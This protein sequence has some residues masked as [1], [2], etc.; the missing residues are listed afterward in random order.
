M[1]AEISYERTVTPHGRG[2]SVPNDQAPRLYDF[3]EQSMMAAV[4][5]FNALEMF[6]NQ[7][8]ADK[9]PDTYTRTTKRRQEEFTAEKLQRQLST[10]EKLATVLPEILEIDPPKGTP[11]WS[12]FGKLKRARDST[13]H[14]KT[15]DAYVA[16]AVDSGS[17]FQEFFAMRSLLGYPIFAVELIRFFR[18]PDEEKH[19][20][21]R[22]AKD[23]LQPHNARRVPDPSSA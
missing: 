5:S 10:E 8:I 20:W 21:L 4:F 22:Y 6:C 17:L 11:V 2:R 18:K 14:M 3:F 16:G 9:V 7:T 13:I 15:P 1:R 23:S 19:R 12:D